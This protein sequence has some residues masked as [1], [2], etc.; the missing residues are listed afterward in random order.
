MGGHKNRVDALEGQVSLQAFR[1][2]Q[3]EVLEIIGQID[4]A[5][6]DEIIRRLE[7]RARGVVD[8]KRNDAA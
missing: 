2:F 1:E 8:E 7:L 5:A 4:P 3:A 6:R